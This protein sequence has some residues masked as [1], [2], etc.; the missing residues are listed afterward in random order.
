MDTTIIEMP[1]RILAVVLGLAFVVTAGI[2]TRRHMGGRP[3]GWGTPV[4]FF[5][6]HAGAVA[7]PVLMRMGELVGEESG[8][9]KDPPPLAADSGAASADTVLLMVAL[10]ILTV[11]GTAVGIWAL[12]S[13]P[14][15]SA[16]TAAVRALR[17]RSTSSA[18]TQSQLDRERETETARLWDRHVAALNEIKG[19]YVEFE[20]DPWSAFRRPL[21]GDVTEPATAAF[22]DA[23]AHAQDL[24][25]DTRPT[26]RELVNDFGAAVRA[27]TRAWQAADQ[28]ARMIAVPATTDTDRRRLR[29]AEDALHLALDE[30]TS[31]AERRVAL[32]R[33]EELIKGL[34]IMAP[35][36]RTTIVAEIDHIERRA[37]TG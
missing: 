35:K 20:T 32:G 11:G 14:T 13:K 34:T 3:A 9:D 23:F 25:T 24:H 18:P 19:S 27:A 21:L 6:L 15:S 8:P 29:Q 30:R 17:R 36:A 28:H 12:R 2:S 4:S 16:P 5:V 26:S 31:A 33:V 10:G 37:I 7:M 22:H 1:L